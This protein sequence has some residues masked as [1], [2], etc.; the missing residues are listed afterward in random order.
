MS[1]RLFDVERFL[2]DYAY[3]PGYL[4]IAE[5]KYLEGNRAINLMALQE[6]L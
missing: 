1:D 4:D 6:K 3:L 2:A 5:Q